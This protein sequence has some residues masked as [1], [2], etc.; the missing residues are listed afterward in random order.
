[1][2]GAWI[3]N[4]VINYLQ[5]CRSQRPAVVLTSYC[6][7]LNSSF[8]VRHRLWLKLSGEKNVFISSNCSWKTKCSFGQIINDLDITTLTVLENFLQGTWSSF[9]YCRPYFLDK[10]ATRF[11]RCRFVFLWSLHRL[12]WCAGR[13]G[14]SELKSKEKNRRVRR[15]ETC[16]KSKVVS[17][18]DDI[19][20][21]NHRCY[22]RSRLM[23]LALAKLA[24]SKRTDEVNAEK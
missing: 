7:L 13:D 2:S 22:W 5:K 15:Q 4:N 24:L 19:E 18:E 11:W 16:K 6:K 10:V 8:P 23:A 1:M 20:T 9:D 3:E 17:I 21:G 14:Q 12:S